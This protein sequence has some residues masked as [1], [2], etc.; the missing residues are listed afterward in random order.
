MGDAAACIRIALRSHDPRCPFV[1]DAERAALALATLDRTCTTAPAPGPNGGNKAAMLQIRACRQQAANADRLGLA[2]SP[3]IAENAVTACKDSFS[4]ACMVV[5]R[6]EPERLSPLSY[7][8][9]NLW[10][11]RPCAEVPEDERAPCENVRVMRETE[12]DAQIFEERK[13]SLASSLDSLANM[14][15]ER[16]REAALTPEQRAA[17]QAERNRQASIKYEE[18]RK[19]FSEWEK[20]QA[21]KRAAE[22]ARARPAPAAA[23]AP[24]DERTYGPKQPTEAY[25]CQVQVCIGTDLSGRCNSYTTLGRTC[26]R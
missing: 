23:P 2:W 25:L 18:H 11:K 16:Q 5:L 6:H 20:Q 17:E 8:V 21:E 13:R 10:N 24:R 3:A 4:D 26:Y 1:A 9:G 15:A 7:F 22:E 14:Q 19:Q 12:L